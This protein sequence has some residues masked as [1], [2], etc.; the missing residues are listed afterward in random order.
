MAADDRVLDGRG[1]TPPGRLVGQE[2]IA[3]M[4]ALVWFPVLDLV[5]GVEA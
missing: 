2:E 4:I 3:H 1:S 5:T